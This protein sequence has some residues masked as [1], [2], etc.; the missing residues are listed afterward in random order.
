MSTF[1]L[2]KVSLQLKSSSLT[3]SQSFSENSRIHHSRIRPLAELPVCWLGKQSLFAHRPGGCR[4]TASSSSSTVQ[5]ER[6]REEELFA[7]D[8][9]R[10]GGDRN[11]NQ[12]KDDV[13][14]S[15]VGVFCV[16]WRCSV[17]NRLLLVV[18]LMLRLL[19]P[20][21]EPVEL[22]SIVIQQDAFVVLLTRRQFIRKRLQRI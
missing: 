21:D 20:T 14:Y 16:V 22:V 8:S 15:L 2:R 1:R 5:R 3:Q 11:R 6:Q 19:R 13:D 18:M 7:R 10:V 17:I 9:C 12:R 4:K